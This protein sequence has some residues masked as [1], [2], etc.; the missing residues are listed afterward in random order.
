MR[1]LQRPAAITILL[2]LIL[3][4]LFFNVGQVSAH[5]VESDGGTAAVLHMPPADSPTAGEN[6]YIGLAFSSDSSDFN[7]AT[8]DTEVIIQRGSE[9]IQTATLATQP[10]SSRDGSATVVFPTAG[11][12]RVIVSGTPRQLGE[13]FRLT[14]SVR[15]SSP[16]NITGG[17]TTA[18][19]DFWIL[20]GGSLILLAIAARHNTRRGKRY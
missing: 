17:N 5:I 2:S 15:A 8:Y 16:A 12:Y 11:A 18:G 1:Q 6:T 14:Y 20:S 9:T 19:V 7:I 4:P 13:A 10:E 3:L